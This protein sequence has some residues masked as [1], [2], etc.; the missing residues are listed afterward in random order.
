[1]VLV[2]VLVLVQ[3]QVK[4][5]GRWDPGCPFPC[6]SVPAMAYRYPVPKLLC[7]TDLE[8]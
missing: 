7:I 5:K 3:V 4:V 2:R 6:H 8:S 1:M